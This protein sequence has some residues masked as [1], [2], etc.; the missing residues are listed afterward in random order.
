MSHEYVVTSKE[1]RPDFTARLFYD[2][3]PENPRKWGTQITSI[4]FWDDTHGN[5]SDSREIQSY[6]EALHHLY[7]ETYPELV[8]LCLEDEPPQEVLDLI[9]H[10]PYP[11]I[12]RWIRVWD[13]RGET[14]LVPMPDPDIEDPH[15]G[16]VAFIS[17]EKL[18]QEDFTREEGEIIIQNDLLELEQY[19]NGNVYFLEIHLDDEEEY[20]GSIY[21]IAQTGTRAGRMTLM[22]NTHIPRDEDLD[23]HLL[24][25][26]ISPEDRLLVSTASWE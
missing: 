24:D 1:V 2:D 11:G 22:E 20:H 18:Q 8:D 12:I 5:L 16:G 15:I 25:M 17:D 26:D 3:S 7:Q 6:Q 9:D 14:S 4:Y 19:I 21:P 13:P 23:D 10:T